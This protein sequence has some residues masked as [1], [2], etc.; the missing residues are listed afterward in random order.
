MANVYQEYEQSGRDE[1]RLWA[2][3][4]SM[5]WNIEFS[6]GEFD[7]YDGIMYSGYSL[8]A[9]ELKKRKHNHT[10]IWP[11]NMPGF[12]LE[13]IKYDGLKAVDADEQFF[14]T[15]FEDCIVIWNITQLKPEWITRQYATNHTCKEKVNK[16][17]CY[18]TL[19]MASHII[20]KQ[21]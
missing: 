19:E 6:K 8:V 7:K 3:K 12:I 10:K 17:V 16:Q 21:P 18:L 14:I 9:I 2:N 15:M 20:K 1:F 5:I 4:N 11:G 13:K